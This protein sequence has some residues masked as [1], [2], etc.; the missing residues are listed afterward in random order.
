MIGGVLWFA[1]AAAGSTTDW[2]TA[3]PLIVAVLGAALAYGFNLAL[4]RRDET[5]EL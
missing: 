4:K 1:A 5:R 3:V 2:A